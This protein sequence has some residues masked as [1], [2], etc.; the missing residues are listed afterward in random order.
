[1]LRSELDP[2]LTVHRPSIPVQEALKHAAGLREELKG[3]YRGKRYLLKTYGCQMNE[4]DSEMIAGLL[5][6]MGYAATTDE[7]AADLILFNTCAVRENAENKVFGEIGRVKPLKQL[8]PQL[9]LGVCGCMPQE[10]AV[11]ERVR[12]TYPWVDVVF[13]THNIHR[14]PELIEQ[15]S[16]SFETVME[17]WEQSVETL[18]ELPKART[19]Q[20]RAWVNIQYGCNKYCTYCIV[21]YTRGKER[22]RTM[23]SIVSEVV[24]LAARGFKEVTLLGQNV[25]DYGL[26]LGTHFSTLLRAVGSVAG[27]ERVRFTTSNPW[28]FTDDLIEAIAETKTVCHHIHLPVQSGS[29]AILKR[30]NRGYTREYYLELVRKIRERIP[31]V[32]LTTDLIVG[33]PGE[34][35]QD[36]QET[37]TLVSDVQFD[38]AY[39]FSYSARTGTPAAGFMDAVSEDEKKQRLARLMSVQDGY[40][41]AASQRAVGATARVLVEGVSRT[42]GHVLA[43]RTDTNKLVLVEGPPQWIGQSIYVR[44]LSANTWTLRGERVD[45]ESVAMTGS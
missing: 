28:N 6:E 25:N 10:T 31:G 32:A 13:G 21:P 34:T 8:N 40:T 18:D 23:E 27:I 14:M 17:V 36:F 3:A 22:S 2:A 37:L 19:D 41:L 33:F 43:T 39:T 20:T 30:M 42:N 15:A 16:H 45:R 1:M 29:N 24:D 38:N 5:E 35:E 12:S 44:I 26:D 9:L 7:T 11:Q 4:H